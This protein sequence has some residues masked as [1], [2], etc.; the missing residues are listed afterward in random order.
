MDSIADTDADRIAGPTL[1]PSG[2]SAHPQVGNQAIRAVFFDL[3]DTLCGYWEASKRALRETFE[4]HRPGGCD[5]ETLLREW[6]AAFRVFLPEVKRAPWYEAYLV[7]GE[8]TRTELMRRT[9][10]RLA[11]H[12]PTMATELSSTYSKLRNSYLELFPEAIEV[13]EALKG[14][15]SMGLITNGPADTQRMEIDALDIAGHFEHIFIE[16]V[17]GFGKPDRRVFETAEQ[18][19]GASGRE[20]LFVGN[21]YPHDIYPAI[22][23][24][25]RTAWIRRPTDAPPS[26]SG[27]KSVASQE[28]PDGPEPD[29]EIASLS[30]LLP[31]LGIKG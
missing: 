9:L 25:W 10:E 23:A 18:A 13:I 29:L 1:G 5:A 24:G 8:P 4:H 27:S 28:P 19:V 21:S 22:G 3:D 31:Y 15:Y 11:I 16:G 7:S 2:S 12:D 20:I 6:A 30:E 26:T 14:R 17:L